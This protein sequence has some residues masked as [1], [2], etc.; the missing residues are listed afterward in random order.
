M[1]QRRA[2]RG[3]K[4][5]SRATAGYCGRMISSRFPLAGLAA[6][7]LLF[8][9]TL[10]CAVY[11]HSARSEPVPIWAVFNQ[12]N[13]DLLNNV[14]VALAPGAD[15]SL[16]VGTGG[17]LAR[18]DNEGR[19]QTYTPASTNAGLPNDTVRALAPGAD[20]ALWV[21]TDGGLSHL[22]HLGQTL[23]IV[24]VIGIH[25]E[26]EV[27]QKEQ[28]VAVVAFDSSYLTQPWMFHYA[29]R[30]DEVGRFG[31]RPGP[32]IKT[33]SSVYT[34]RIRPRWRVSAER[35]RP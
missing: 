34:L 29:W 14:V 9:L 21:G 19:W 25:K 1:H 12:E 24:E 18:R 4:M 3:E 13:S 15:G 17:G 5:L 28:T 2:S 6:W 22:K 27:T 31:L 23:Q 20:G 26:G 35:C 8:A 10:C 32:E 33:K 11:S 7:R 30:L 16:W